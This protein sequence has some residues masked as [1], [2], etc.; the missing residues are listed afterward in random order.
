[1]AEPVT[2]E[3]LG[4]KGG[5]LSPAR[6]DRLYRGSTALFAVGVLL[7]SVAIG[8]ALA[9]GA[10]PA[11]RAFGWRF[12]TGRTWDP[13]ADHYGALPFILGTLLTSLLALL[14][15]LPLSLAAAIFLA[16]LAPRWL[17]TPVGFAIE[18]LAAIPSIVYGLWGV[19]VML[20]RLVP[21]QRWLDAHLGFVCFLRGDAVGPSLM[22]GVVILA[23]M[24]LPIL[25]SLSREVLEA[26]PNSVREAAF[27]VGATHWE[28]LRGPVLDYGRAGILGAA[29]LG[30]GRA[31][32]ETMAVT[33]VIGN[34]TNL[35]KSL[36]EPAYTMSSVLANEFAE[37]TGVLHISSLM[38]IALLLFGLTIIVNIVA[39]LLLWSVGAGGG[40][41]L[42]D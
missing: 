6:R 22:A 9:H 24:I 10:S 7:L 11:W 27:A 15:A 30:L 17:R 16:D 20:P 12:L 29:L 32:G 25:T 5:W 4:G 37:A 2:S 28:T 8:M 26:V 13:V 21:C 42:R 19:F 36:L 40:G 34:S 23:I 18:L 14:L 41:A 1:M 33:M 39:R 3:A 31:L 35:P 38:S